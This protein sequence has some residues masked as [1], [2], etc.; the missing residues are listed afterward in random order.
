M[1]Y[2]RVAGFDEL[3]VKVDPEGMLLTLLLL[4]VLVLVLVHYSQ[5]RMPTN[6][7]PN[8]MVLGK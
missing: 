2:S 8:V 1:A 7:Y 4:L 5:S 3:P 6:I